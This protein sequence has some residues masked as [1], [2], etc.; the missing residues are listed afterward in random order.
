MEWH[1]SVLNVSVKLTTVSFYMNPYFECTIK[2]I[3]TQINLHIVQFLKCA[4]LKTIIHIPILLSGFFSFS[5]L[6]RSQPHGYENICFHIFKAFAHALS[7]FIT[8]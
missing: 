2:V 6:L 5:G 7:L 8:D 1:I 4:Y 3:V